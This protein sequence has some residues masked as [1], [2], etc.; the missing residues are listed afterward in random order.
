MIDELRIDVKYTGCTS[1][2][3]EEMSTA[4]TEGFEPSDPVRGLHLSRVVH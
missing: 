4:E 1:L 2:H 3:I